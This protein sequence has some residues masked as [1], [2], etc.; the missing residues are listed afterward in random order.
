MTGCS[1]GSWDQTPEQPGSRWIRLLLWISKTMGRRAFEVSLSPVVACYAAFAKGAR[2]ESLRYLARVKAARKQAGLPP[3]SEPLTPYRHFRHFALSVYDRLEAW[4]P[5]RK[6]RI[7][8]LMTDE[9]RAALTP[10]PGA[11]G[12]LVLM[13]HFGAAEV[14]RA[15]AERDVEARVIALLYEKNAEGFTR[16]MRTVAPESRIDVVPVDKMGAETAVQLSDAIQSGAWVA[17]AAD[18]T[19]VTSDRRTI[20]TVTIPFLGAPAEFPAGPWVLASL[21][22]CEVWTLFASRDGDAFRVSFEKLADRVTLPRAS[23]NDAIR[24]YALDFAERLQREVIHSPLEWFNFY[25]FWQGAGR[26]FSRGKN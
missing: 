26:D 5:D 10:V 3:A 25:D 11:P 24:R 13:S 1:D 20:R 14:C 19:P 12:K 16:V 21:L 15:V 18:R 6:H 2:Q 22:G 4:D 23:R 17:I 9:A 7:H 8:L